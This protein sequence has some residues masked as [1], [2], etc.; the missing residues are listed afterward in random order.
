MA[1]IKIDWH[2]DARTLRSFGLIGFC[3]FG[4]FSL[5]ALGRVWMFAKL[6]ANAWVVLGPLAVGCGLLAL[7]APRLLR[8][9]YLLLS[10]VGYPI[11]LVVSHVV[12]FVIFYF[13][14]TPVGLVFKA[15][16]RD[17]MHRRWDAAAA[18]Y[19]VRRRS[20]ESVKRYF[21]QF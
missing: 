20:P 6:P 7:T 13:V 1:I 16:G 21:R 8:P 11:G 2:P 9:L 17:A 18:S 4:A 3:A 5:L 14:V 12:L 19:W 15:I 10:V